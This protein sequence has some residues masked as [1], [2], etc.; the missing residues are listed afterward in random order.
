MANSI[1]EDTKASLGLAVDHTAFDAEIRMFINSVLAEAAQLG[2][3]PVEG[4]EVKSASTKWTEITDDNPLLNNLKVYVHMKVKL[5]FDP[6]DVGYVLDAYKGEI[7][8]VEWR[9]MVASDP[10]AAEVTVD[11]PYS[12]DYYRTGWIPYGS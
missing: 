2:V 3:G 8:K 11:P 5:L 6:P 1:L 4:V 10:P 9:L 7:E 12:D